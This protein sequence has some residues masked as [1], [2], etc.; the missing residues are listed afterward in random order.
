MPA[1]VVLIAA[2]GALIP[3]AGGIGLHR[4]AVSVGRMG[5]L[6]AAVGTHLPVGTGVGLIGGGPLV[7]SF[8]RAGA[9]AGQTFALML[10]IIQLLP[11]TPIIMA[12]IC[13]KGHRRQAQSH[14]GCQQAGWQLSGP[15][16]SHM[17]PPIF[18]TN[19]TGICS[20]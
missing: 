18:Q 6:R 8:L 5:G 2:H 4:A 12:T 7:R 19:C 20:A 10:R 15:K 17:Q 14:D 11:G 16:S 1:Q 13:R 9:S 3:V